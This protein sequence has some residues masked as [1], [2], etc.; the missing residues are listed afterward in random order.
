MWNKLLAELGIVVSQ[1]IRRVVVDSRD[2]NAGDLFVALN[3]GWQYIDEAI[4]KGAVVITEIKHTHPSV[5]TVPN[6]ITL[7]GDL[8]RL[9][10]KSLSATV[11]GITGSVGKT[12]LTQ[13]LFQALSKYGD[14]SATAY[15]QN[16]EIGVALTLLRAKA[17]IQYLIV[18]MGVAK[19]GDMDYLMSIVSPDI[20]VITKIGPSHLEGLG[21]RQGVWNEKKAILAAQKTIVNKDCLFCCGA[22]ATLTF[23]HNIHS[24]VQITQEGIQ[25]RY[26]K[27]KH[28]HVPSRMYAIA[29][30][31]AIYELLALKPNF[32]FVS[33][34]PA[35][36]E[37]K[38][39]SNGTIV[40]NDCYNANLLSY[41]EAIRYITN[42]EQRLVIIGEM[43]GLGEKSEYYHQ[44]LG[45]VL[46]YF[47]IDMVWLIGKQHVHTL[48]TYTGEARYFDNKHLL[49]EA[50]T[51][52][53]KKGLC[54][55]VKGSRH[56]QL[57]EIL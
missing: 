34:P 2:L 25:S 52:S 24:D 28:S 38:L 32:Q 46:N 54:I 3:T 50:F 40:I 14:T 47:H 11:I 15:N 37:R 45:R 44:I 29:A 41:I 12:S 8:A 53:H 21:S 33:W 27:D 17:S 48:A 30:A 23:G 18:E 20:G 43:G 31:Y 6:T 10:R 51:L 49:K 9:Y 36:L 55:L 39:Y 19:Q 35:R 26:H 42:Y 5:T 16:N 56:L 7:L 4:A 1:E 57:E 22:G 13:L